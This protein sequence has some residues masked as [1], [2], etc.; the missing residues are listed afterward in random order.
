MEILIQNIKDV[1]E[2]LNKLNDFLNYQFNHDEDE[3]TSFLTV[4][5]NI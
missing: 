2:S 4:L 3:I 1:E 5:Y